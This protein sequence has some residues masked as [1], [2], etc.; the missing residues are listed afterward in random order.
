MT[1]RTTKGDV[2]EFMR[3]QSVAVET[4][5]SPSGVPQAAIVGFVVTDA[6]EIFFDTLDSTR[7]VAN[8]RQNPQVAFV[9][10]GF[11]ESDERTVQFQGMVDEPGGEELERL[12]KLYFTRFPKGRDRLSWP[13]LIYLRARPTWLRFSD[14]ERAPPEIAEFDF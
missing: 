1:S 4:S 13:G 12:K 6:F 11:A 3:S 5:V 10:G 2:L 14:F 7:K 8:L 9:V